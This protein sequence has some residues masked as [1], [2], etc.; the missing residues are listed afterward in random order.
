MWK[1]WLGSGLHGNVSS[2]SYIIE[3]ENIDDIPK[4]LIELLKHYK[5]N[6]K[7]D[8]LT[9]IHFKLDLESCIK[10]Y[11]DSYIQK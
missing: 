10:L 4:R 6:P 7:N 8:P 11:S 9:E 3:I 2:K 1:S 5:N